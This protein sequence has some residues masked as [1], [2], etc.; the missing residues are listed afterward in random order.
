MKP[1]F[2][3]KRQRRRA[4]R[5]V[6]AL[7]LILYLFCLPRKLFDVPYATVVTDRYGELLGARIANDGQWRF[8][9]CDTV[10]E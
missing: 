5:W 1:F 7:L 10:P 4:I 2:K 3:N 8:P 6:I 9:P